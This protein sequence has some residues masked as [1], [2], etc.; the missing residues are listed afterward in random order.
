[1]SNSSKNPPFRRRYQSKSARLHLPKSIVG[2][3]VSHPESG[4]AYLHFEKPIEGIDEHPLASAFLAHESTRRLLHGDLVRARLSLGPKGIYATAEALLSQVENISIFGSLK[5]AD[6]RWIFRP[7][8]KFY[9]LSPEG[10]WS[11]YRGDGRPFQNRF[12]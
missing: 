9:G 6:S 7:S 1:M 8:G 4:I 5:R 12:Q 10:R 11:G 2:R 3:V